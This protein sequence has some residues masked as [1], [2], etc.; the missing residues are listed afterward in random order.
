[1]YYFMALR[2]AYQRLQF[3]VRGIIVILEKDFI[4]EKHITRH[5]RLYVKKKN[6][7]C[8]RLGIHLRT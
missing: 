2:M 8:I 7:V 3:P 1:M 5:Y 4:L 6:H